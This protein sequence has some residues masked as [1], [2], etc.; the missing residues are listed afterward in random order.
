M[1]TPA[2]GPTPLDGNDQGAPASALRAWRGLGRRSPVESV[3]VL[4][5]DQDSQVYRLYTADGAVVAKSSVNA[6]VSEREIYDVVLPQVGLSTVR[7]LGFGLDTRCDRVWMFL[8]EAAGEAY[9]ETSP[10]HRAAASRWLGRLHAGTAGWEQADRLPAMDE[11]RFRRDL[12][13]ALRNIAEALPRAAADGPQLRAVLAQLKRVDANWSDVQARLEAGPRCVVHGDFYAKNIRVINGA[14][15]EL[16][17]FDWGR[18]G[19]GSPAEELAG[20][21]A[22]EYA[23]GAADDAWTRAVKP[24]FGV[25][26]VLRTVGWIHDH[27]IGLSSTWPEVSAR[28]LGECAEQLALDQLTVGW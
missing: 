27:S 14:S 3:A 2:S 19:Y 25:A 12:E 5:A 26:G 20:L 22:N 21:D 4:K 23:R 1:T 24:L 11:T 15:A 18:S 8:D 10:Q 6:L 17:V 28:K 13:G 9:R 16:A 7:Y